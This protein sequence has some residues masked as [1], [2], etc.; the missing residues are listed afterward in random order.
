L[1]EQVIKPAPAKGG[2]A[3]VAAAEDVAS[4]PIGFFLVALGG[5]PAS[6]IRQYNTYQY[7]NKS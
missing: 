5:S 6:D 3:K 1:Y 7:I 4:T 2:R